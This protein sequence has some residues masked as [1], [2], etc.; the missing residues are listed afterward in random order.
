RPAPDGTGSWTRLLSS[1]SGGTR[2]AVR[3]SGTS[4]SSRPYQRGRPRKC[5]PECSGPRRE[6]PAP[7]AWRDAGE[8]G[9]ARCGCAGRLLLLQGRGEHLEC[10]VDRPGADPGPPAAV[11]EVRGASGPAP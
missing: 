11:T 1:D 3:D 10:G 4:K 9:S 7:C 6:L 2:G 5:S 8:D